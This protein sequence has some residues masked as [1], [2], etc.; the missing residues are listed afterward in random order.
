M[1]EGR[2]IFLRVHPHLLLGFG[3]FHQFI[4]D[5]GFSNFMNF[6][7]FL[8]QIV[9]LGGVKRSCETCMC[10]KFIILVE[11]EYLGLMQ[12]FLRVKECI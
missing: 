12:V 4:C 3:A 11:F 6:G 9:Q 10:D 2:E 8:I 1:G 5:G 7:I